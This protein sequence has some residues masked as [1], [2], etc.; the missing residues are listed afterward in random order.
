MGIDCNLKKNTNLYLTR[1]C[2][3][4][5]NCHQYKQ[6]GNFLFQYSCKY[7][8]SPRN[9][10]YK[11]RIRV[12]KKR[13]HR[14]KR[15]VLLYLLCNRLLLRIDHIDNRACGNDSAMRKRSIFSVRSNN[16]N[17]VV[18]WVLLGNGESLLQ[19]A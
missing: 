11:I 17:G 6:G 5:D 14:N 10:V 4:V 18:L 2:T 15:C 3:G 13:T 1:D 8:Q 16:L 12:Q 7:C 9:L 19:D